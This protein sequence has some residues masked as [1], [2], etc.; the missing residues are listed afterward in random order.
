M[1]GYLMHVGF[2]SQVSRRHGQDPA[3]YVPT[4][5]FIEA[6]CGRM[7][8]GLEAALHLEP[9]LKPLLDRMDESAIA[10]CFAQVRGET[11]LAGLSRA[12]AHDL[13]FVRIFNHRL[14]GGRALALLL[15]RD[16]GDGPLATA[17]VPWSLSDVVEHCGISRVQAKRL[18]DDALSEGLIHIEQGQLTWLEHAR[19][20]I[21]FGCAFEFAG[22]LV[23]AARTLNEFGT[24]G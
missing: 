24:C 10:V 7:R 1:L 19:Q 23:A 2:I 9:S 22:M 6:W 5:R 14:G 12:T 16:S 13:P 8:R 20:F 15:S 11:I 3:V 17:S 18:F 21:A 4:E